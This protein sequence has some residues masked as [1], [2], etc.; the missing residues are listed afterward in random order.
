[1]TNLRRTMTVSAAVATTGLLSMLGLSG[2]SS[3]APSLAQ[4]AVVSGQ[5]FL[6]D[7]HVKS[8]VYPGEKVHKGSGEISWYMWCN[9]RN[10]VI[11]GKNADSDSPSQVRTAP[12]PKNAAAALPIN[13]NTFTTWQLN[14]NRSALIHFLPF[15]LKYG[16]ATNTDQTDSGNADLTRSSNPGWNNMLSE[17]V[18]PAIDAAVADAASQVGPDVWTDRSQWQH[19]GELISAALPAELNKRTGSSTPY[20]CGTNSTRTNCTNP[21][22]LVQNVWPADPN[23]VQQYNQKIQSQQGGAVG[24]ARRDAATATYGSLAD[25]A[26]AMQDLVAKCHELGVPCNIYVG[27]PAPGK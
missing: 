8:V 6:D 24:K 1:M 20:F 18:R 11:G 3:A 19:F 22:V 2:C 4:C 10:Y 27:Q 17:V 26:L 9:A 14:Q 21:T 25:W 15:C 5:G 7:Q 16:C 13:V 12:A 23:I